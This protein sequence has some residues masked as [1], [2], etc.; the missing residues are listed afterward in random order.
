MRWQHA[1][2]SVDKT[3]H[4][5]AGE[6]L[7]NFRFDRVGKYHPP[8][9]AP[10]ER[11]GE[12]W[13]VDQAGEALYERRFHRTFGFYDERAAVDDGKAWF[14]IGLD[15]EPIGS[16]RHEW[17]GN[18][19]EGCAPVRSFAQ[20]YY[21]VE[22]DGRATYQRHWCYA[23]DFRDG[24]AVVQSDDGRSTHI[25]RTGALVHERWFLDLDVFHKTHARAR[26]R[27]GWMHVDTRGEPIYGR[28]FAAVEPFYNG[29]ARVETFDGGLLVIDEE[30]H[31]LVQL[32]ASSGSDFMRLSSDLVGYWRTHAIAAA[33]ELGLFEGLPA[34]ET[35]L[36]AKCGI[37]VE[38]LQRLLRALGELGLVTRE[39]D[40]WIALGKASPLRRDHPLSLSDAALEY[41]GPLSEVWR[42]LV[43]ALREAPNWRS[44]GL[45]ETLASA[46]MAL[47]RHH[48]ALRGYARHDY[49]T[50]AEVLPALPGERVIDAGGS[51]GALMQILLERR[52]DLECVV[53]D[54]P[55]VLALM[56]QVP[57]GLRRHPA[58]LFAD[59]QIRGDV[60]VLA[61]VLHDWNDESALAILARARA[62]LRPGGRIVILE[63]MLPNLASGDYDGG[64]CDLHLLACHGGRERDLQQWTSLLSRAE[65]E[66]RQV[67]PLGGVPSM[68]VV[69]SK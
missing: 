60:V 33:V 65:L 23:G 22:R 10:V 54:R 59:W 26:D 63:M 14:H 45:F 8:G 21:H 40:V 50:L 66:L 4:E 27:G 3:H 18:F 12:A 47:A 9:V 49:T 2:M 24:I 17:C 35:T 5:I 39:R 28:R 37:S 51:S 20:R 68:L 38:Q 41:A 25:D 52:S 56:D 30:G 43:S 11:G 34:D 42:P 67:V 19:Q 31:T 32:R 53:L 29:Q 62:A 6:P 48:R 57:P 69:E 36:A 16:G 46:P 64:L 7:Y 55:E 58:D 61:R 15:G 1:R 13:H 44:P